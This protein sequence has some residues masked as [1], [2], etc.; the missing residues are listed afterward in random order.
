VPEILQRLEEVNAIL[1]HQPVVDPEM[2]AQ[3]L[4]AL[5]DGLLVISEQGSI[6]H[7][8]QQIE[9]LFGYPRSM[10]VGQSVHMLLP[11]ELAEAHAGHIARFFSH[12]TV[13]PMNMAKA[14]PGRHRSGR[15]ITVQISLGPVVS[16]QGVLGLAL[17]RRVLDAC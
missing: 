16:T 4:D 3:I 1:D 17:V 11:P 10:L 14:L 13:R 8:N 6:R 9:L 2:F 5:P 12:P 7:V 15:T